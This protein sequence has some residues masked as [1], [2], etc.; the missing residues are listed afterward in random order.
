MRCIIQVN[1]ERKNEAIFMSK[2]LYII[3]YFIIVFLIFSEN[4][5][6]SDEKC[7]SNFYGSY[8][9]CKIDILHVIYLST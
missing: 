5:I 4:V 8:Y 3:C 2:Q 6:E 7:T 1:D 9:Q